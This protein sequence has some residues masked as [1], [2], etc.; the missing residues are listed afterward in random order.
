[1]KKS[2]RCMFIILT[3]VLLFSTGVSASPSTYNISELGLD[4][5]IPSGY[6]VITRDTPANDS[7][8]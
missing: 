5:T 6:K 7:V 3:V 8:G 4:I 2:I 1:M